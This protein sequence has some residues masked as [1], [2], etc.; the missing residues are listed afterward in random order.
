M[1][2]DVSYFLLGV[3]EWVVE[4]PVS[5]VVVVSCS[6]WWEYYWVVLV[7]VRRIVRDGF[8]L[9]VDWVLPIC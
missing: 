2:W 5:T 3:D 6:F 7:T 1:F 8:D 4:F 9:G